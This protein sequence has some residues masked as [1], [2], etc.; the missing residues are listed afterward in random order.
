MATDYTE[1]EQKFYDARTWHG[2]LPEA[3]LKEEPKRH[4]LAGKTPGVRSTSRQAYKQIQPRLSEKQQEVYVAI[5]MSKRPVCD[6]E[7]VSYL[8]MSISSVTA[9]RNELVEMGK[10]QEAFRAINPKT[11][12]RVIYWKPVL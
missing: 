11:N 5:Q 7:L 12:K 8:G 6:T 4:P 10:I 9:R 3:K 2:D 1:A